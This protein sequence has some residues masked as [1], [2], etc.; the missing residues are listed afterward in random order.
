MRRN[1]EAR[2]R[3]AERQRIAEYRATHPL[4]TILAA[5]RHNAK[6]RSTA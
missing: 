3:E 4:A 1:N 6:K 2:D 5:M